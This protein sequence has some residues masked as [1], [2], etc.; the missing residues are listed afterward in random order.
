MDWIYYIAV[1]VVIVA[2]VWWMMAKKKKSPGDSPKEPD[3][4]NQPTPPT[5]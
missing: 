3:Q 5:V 4:F 1:A 2:F